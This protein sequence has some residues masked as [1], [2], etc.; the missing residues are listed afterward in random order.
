VSGYIKENGIIE[1]ESLF[2]KKKNTL[3][4]FI[5]SK[6]PF[7]QRAVSTAMDSLANMNESNR[8]KLEVHYIFIK[9]DKG[10]S[11][12]HGEQ[13]INE[14]MVQIVLRNNYPDYFYRY[15]K[16]RIR[17]NDADWKVLSK[18]IGLNPTAIQNI[19]KEI[20]SN[21]ND[22]IQ[23]EYNYA[24]KNYQIYDNSPTYIW[25]SEKISNLKEIPALKNIPASEQKCSQ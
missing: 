11:S 5:M 24:V 14:D 2:K 13:E 10:F 17:Y 1:V 18:S 25:E 12:L 7:G 15:L 23:R 21:R 8:F 6:C 20:V 16:T 4:I 19:E 3:E 22:I 9:F